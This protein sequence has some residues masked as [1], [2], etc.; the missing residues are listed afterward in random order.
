M[1]SAKGEKRGTPTYSPGLLEN[2]RIA[3]LATYMQIYKKGNVDLKGRGIV[4]KWMPHKCY[5]WNIAT[6]EGYSVTQHA[7]GIFVNKQGQDSC[8]K[9][10]K[11]SKSWGSF[12]KCVKKYGRKPEK[13]R[14]PKR[15]VLEFSWSTHLPCLEKDISWEPMEASLNCCN[16]SW[17][18]KCKENKRPGFFF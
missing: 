14:N 8:Q 1:T 2:L 3:P 17:Q 4:Q 16:T 9:H 18:D 13:E 5:N 15:N 6:L 10:I 12:L 11:H 7:V